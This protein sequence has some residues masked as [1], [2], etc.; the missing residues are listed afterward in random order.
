MRVLL[1][2]GPTVFSV[3]VLLK[4][5]F[6]AFKT[7]WKV[8]N[9]ASLLL[10]GCLY[11]SSFLCITLVHCVVSKV[12]FLDKGWLIGLVQCVLAERWKTIKR[13]RGDKMMWNNQGGKD[14]QNESGFKALTFP[15][16]Q[17]ATWVPYWRAFSS[18][19]TWPSSPQP[20]PRC[21]DRLTPVCPVYDSDDRWYIW[22]CSRRC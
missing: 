18:D 1:A 16:S 4:N 3:S 15:W 17:R 5:L 12:L 11:L 13:G 20:L 10:Y 21:W 8:S 19:E 2:R 9:C 14:E 22:S 6:K 7:I